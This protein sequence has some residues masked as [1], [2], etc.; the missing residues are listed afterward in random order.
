ML[1]IVKGSVLIE[2]RATGWAAPAAAEHPPY[3][4]TIDAQTA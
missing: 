2:R 1:S 3:L 4:K